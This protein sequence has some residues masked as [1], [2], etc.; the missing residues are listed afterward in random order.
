MRKRKYRDLIMNTDTNPDTLWEQITNRQGDVF[1]TKKGLP[2]TYYIKGGEL[3]ASRR[4]RSITR[5][6]FE[7]ALQKI[8]ENP[9]EI[10]G[11]KKLNVYGAPYV[12]AVLATILGA[13]S[14]KEE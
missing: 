10:S 8:Q 9:Q 2:F 7:K 13:E 6:T 5:S 1:Y 4:E 14:D 3:F 12:W 11:P